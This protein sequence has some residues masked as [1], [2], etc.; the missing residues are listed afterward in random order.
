MW[1]NNN[2][3]FNDELFMDAL[4]DCSEGNDVQI[5]DYESSEND[6]IVRPIRQNNR[7]ILLSETEDDAVS[8]TSDTDEDSVVND[9]DD[10]SQND[11]ELQLEA[12]GRT[13]SVNTLPQDQENVWEIVQLFLG[14]D[15]FE[16]FVTETNRYHSQVVNRYKEYK[17]LRWV[18]VTVTEMKKFLGLIILMGQIRKD[19]I[20][21]YWST[22][23]YIETPIFPKIMSRNRFMQI[24]RMWHFCNNDLLYDK[25]DKLFKIREVLNYVQ[26]KFQT[27]YTPKQELSLD[28]GIIPW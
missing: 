28:E 2:E 26:N 27:V 14:N 11:I 18:D 25:T 15:L 3:N 19:D 10:W 12:Y 7:R 24:W 5:S 17:T 22:L 6:S 4:S 9:D 16:L 20:Y 1:R 8:S 23:S 21:D 13:S